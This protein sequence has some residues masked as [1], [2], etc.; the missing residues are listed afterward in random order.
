[1]LLLIVAGVLALALILALATYL[2]GVEE[3]LGPTTTELRLTEDV[4]FLERITPDMVEPVEVPER[5]VSGQSVRD[6]DT[7]FD[8]VAAADLAQGTTL[9]QSMLTQPPQIQDGQREVAILIDPETGV[10]GRIQAGDVVDV[11]ATFGETVLGEGEQAR[12]IEPRSE[13]ILSR[14]RIVAVSDALS[15]PEAAGGPALSVPVTFALSTDQALRLAYAESFATEVRLG[16]RVATDD[17]V[18]VGDARIY[19]EE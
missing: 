19:S 14:V 17:E 18:L 13:V 8:Q 7:L 2:A 10:G 11:I 1:V 9:Q 12:T 4:A 5:W 3:Q 16:R 6:R 15:D